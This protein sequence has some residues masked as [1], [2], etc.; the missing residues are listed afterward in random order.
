MYKI[1]K[2]SNA[3]INYRYL[4]QH[5]L[6]WATGHDISA[7]T[8]L[9]LKYHNKGNPIS[10]HLKFSESVFLYINNRHTWRLFWNQSPWKGMNQFS[11]YIPDCSRSSPLEGSLLSFSFL[12]ALDLFR[13]VV[14]GISKEIK[15][16]WHNQENVV[17]VFEG[18]SH[19][20]KYLCG[21]KVYVVNKVSSNLLGKTS[22]RS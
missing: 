5:T 14:W 8:F 18:N 10:L 4:P 20:K 7:T 16:N 21:S 1:I 15:V 12:A 3:T 9:S 17:I 6:K 19:T 22:S 11:M 13:K 2:R